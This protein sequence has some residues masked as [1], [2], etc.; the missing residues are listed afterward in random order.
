MVY[1]AHD[2]FEISFTTPS[3]AGE[4]LGERGFKIASWKIER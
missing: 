1:D 4:G 3:L 2:F